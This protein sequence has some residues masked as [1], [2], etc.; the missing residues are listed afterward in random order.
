MFNPLT[1]PASTLTHL[2]STGQ[3][4]TVD[5]IKTYLDQI[6]KYESTLNSFISLAPR[7]KLLRTA[8]KLDDERQRV[9][10]RGKLHGV[11]IVLKVCFFFS[12][13]EIFAPSPEAGAD[14]SVDW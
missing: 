6:D 11:P 1:T 9:L 3:T 13:L 4:T 12:P 2:L 7:E 5:V 10:I 14:G 8:E